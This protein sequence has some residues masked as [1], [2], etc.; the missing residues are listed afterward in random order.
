MTI[1]KFLITIHNSVGVTQGDIS[2]ED[3]PAHIPLVGDQ[4][5]YKD[6]AGN[7]K[8]G[9]VVSREFRWI[10]STQQVILTVEFV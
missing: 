6:E 3:I 2:L 5:A 7:D 4:I 1:T 9:L 8:R 10:I